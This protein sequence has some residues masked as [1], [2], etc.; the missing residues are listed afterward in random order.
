MIRNGQISSV[1][2]IRS[3]IERYEELPAHQ[4][5]FLE[6]RTEAALAEAAQ[7]DAVV[8]AGAT[9]GPLH[10]IPIVCKD[11]HD[12]AG[13]AYS[14]GSTILTKLPALKNSGPIDA[15]LDAGAVILGFTA[16]HELG[17][18]ASSIN[19]HFGTP[20][21]P[22]DPDRVPGGS[23][24]G[25]GVA[26]A[27]GMALGGTG[28]DAGGSVRTPAAHCGICG[29]KPTFGLIPKNGVLALTPAQGV[30]GP[31]ARS[32]R[33]C[34]VMT[35][36]LARHDRRDNFS[37]DVGRRDY[38]AGI[39]IGVSGR[40]LAVPTEHFYDDLPAAITN[41]IN[42]SIAVWRSLGA[43]IHYVKVPWAAGA[44]EPNRQITAIEAPHQLAEIMA[45]R[46]RFSV[47]ADDVQRR[48]LESANEPARRLLQL[49]ENMRQ[50]TAQ[51]EEFFRQFDAM[52]TPTNYTTAGRIDNPNLID[53]YLRMDAV[54]GVF[55]ATHQPSLAIPNGFDEQGLPTSVMIS[56]P[57]FS[58]AMLFRI[59]HAF[60]RE[61]DFHTRIPT[62]VR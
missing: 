26:V 37:V 14:G 56:G 52:I 42:R 22:W 7:R 32:A 19:Q 58:D 54:P 34:A 20:A 16:M 40:R 5:A 24:G 55:N 9:L 59:A 43:E 49:A 6:L 39:G 46:D 36:A 10:G 4:G 1:E 29:H 13:R 15:L 21:N 27:A 18:G 11:N 33:D 48:L 28:S 17:F 2:L 61:T 47:L 60:Q 25:T 3:C 12:M 38:A 41:N 23:S 57:K 50:I 35:T 62:A 45:D 31:L 53:E 8:A 30:V 51:A 44:V